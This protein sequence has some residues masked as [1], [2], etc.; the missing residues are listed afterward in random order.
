MLHCN[1]SDLRKIQEVLRLI[2]AKLF[3]CIAEDE[4]QRALVSNARSL[5]KFDSVAAERFLVVLLLFHH[6]LFRLVC[7][8]YYN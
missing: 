7:G 6:G 3:E 2:N 1:V 5:C 8:S 4:L